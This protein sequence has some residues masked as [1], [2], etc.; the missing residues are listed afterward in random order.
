M[1]FL[2]TRKWAVFVIFSVKQ[3]SRLYILEGQTREEKEKKRI[4]YCQNDL[5]YAVE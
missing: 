1:L 3:E 4:C 5:I 2:N